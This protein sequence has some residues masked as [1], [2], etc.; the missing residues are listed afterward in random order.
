MQKADVSYLADAV[1]C[2]EY[3]LLKFDVSIASLHL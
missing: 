1:R 3:F 2:C